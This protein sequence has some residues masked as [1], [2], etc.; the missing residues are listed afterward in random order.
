MRKWLGEG[1][2]SGD[3]LVWRD[4]WPEWKN[5]AQVFPSLAQFGTSGPIPV[6]GAVGMHAGTSTP[7]IHT[8][9]S[10]AM[11]IVRP[12]KKSKKFS[13]AIVVTL[14]LISLVL[15][16]VFCIIVMQSWG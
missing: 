8:G 15:V 12:R 10:G 13:V 4:G 16:G 2:V 7:A 5:A 3:S 1:R 9:S 14:G 6:V 11:R